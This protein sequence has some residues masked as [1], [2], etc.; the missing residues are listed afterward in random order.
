M[1]RKSGS[2]FSESILLKQMLERADVRRK[3]IP[4][5]ALLIYRLSSANTLAVRR[6]AA[7]CKDGAVTIG[8]QIAAKP[9]W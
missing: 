8:L 3:A 6:D 4:L 1:I 2:R 9:A 7:H 5:Q